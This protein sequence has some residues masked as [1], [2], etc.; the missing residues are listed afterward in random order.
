[1][2]RD[3]QLLSLLGP[4]KPGFFLKRLCQFLLMLLRQGEQVLMF[5][6]FT[7]KERENM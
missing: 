3:Y 7:K 4:N 6:F 5:I 1:M 2:E